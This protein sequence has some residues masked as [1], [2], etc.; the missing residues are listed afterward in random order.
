MRRINTAFHVLLFFALTVSLIISALLYKLSFSADKASPLFASKPV[1]LCQRFISNIMVE[2]PPSLPNTLLMI[3]GAILG[4]GFLSFIVQLIRTHIFLKRLLAK[5][6]SIPSGLTKVL[7]GLNLTKKVIL[8]KDKN[9]FSFCYGIFFPFIVVSTALIKSLTA[10]ELEAVL[11]HEQ[12]HMINKDPVKVLIGKTFSSM[13]FF[14]PIFRELNK[15]IEAVNEILADQW[16]IN[17]QKTPASLKSALK[18]ILAAPQLNIATVSNASGADY[19]EIRI[20]RLIDPGIKHKFRLSIVSLLTT[21][22]F[23]LVS[24]FLLQTPV[25][26]SHMDTKSNSTYFLC[27]TDQSC[28]KQ[29][30][31]NTKQS[32]N[33]VPTFMNLSDNS[34]DKDSYHY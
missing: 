19:F 20:H 22:L 27:S 14:L 21:F 10:K 2:V 6:T 23:I 34:C 25:S 32:T 12:S 3:V 11:L 5:R 1:F 29:C 24:W 26:A 18:K 15:N 30:H 8:V 31:H 7:E 33:Y 28:S 9:L 13:F 17:C 4:I 16:T